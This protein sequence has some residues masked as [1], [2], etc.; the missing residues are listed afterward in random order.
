M[1]TA[2]T[3]IDQIGPTIVYE[4]SDGTFSADIVLVHG[5]SGHP[6]DTWTSTAPYN[7]NVNGV[8]EDA[9]NR[10]TK[11]R[12]IGFPNLFSKS[13]AKVFWPKDLLPNE[14]PEA[15]VISWGYDVQIDKLFAPVSKSSISHHAETLLHDIANIRRSAADRDKPLVFIAHSLGGIVLKDALSISRTETT[16]FKEILPP[17]RG[18]IFLGT[19]HH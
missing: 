5:L 6:Q 3:R 14:L 15:R 9:S 12:R 10:P 19:P 13:Q 2:E 16:Y 7:T 4:P 8:G 11:K 17:T 18:V 1:T